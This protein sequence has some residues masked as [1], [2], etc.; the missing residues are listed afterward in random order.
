MT[1]TRREALAALAVPAAAQNAGPPTIAGI[2][3]TVF[4]PNLDGKGQ[5]WFHPRICRIPGSPPKL[6]MTLQGI[7]GSDYFHPVQW[8]ESVDLGRTWSEP[9]PVPG[10][11]RHATADG[12]EEGYCDTVPE[13]HARTGSVIAMAHNV[14]YRGGKLARPNDGRFAVYTVRDKDGKWGPVRRLEWVYPDASAIYTSNCS[15][16]VTLPDGDVLVPLTFGPLGRADR[17]VCSV[18]CSF[19]GRELKIV[20]MGNTLRCSV[21]R[22]LLEPSLAQS[23]GVFYM[24]IRAENGQGFATSSKDGLNWNPMTAWA[25]DDGEPV[26]MSTTQQHW[27]THSGR[28]FLV[29]TRRDAI[30]KNVVR[31]RA[32]LWAAAVDTRKLTLIRATE[33]VVIP[34]SGDGV[35]DGANVE[36]QGNFH[37]TAVSADESLVSTGTVTTTRWTGAVRIARIRWSRASVL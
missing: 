27:L 28:L 37:T 23:G 35:R 20:H 15:Q 13:Y 11:G 10:M 14:F 18:R 34:R 21:G 5:T 26:A 8:S 33:R 32:P 4:W 25:F 16:R 6:L 30:N 29:Y 3:Q 1:L 17:G 7:T 22:G 31:W 2:E 12:M 19:D 36:H 9:K 24:T